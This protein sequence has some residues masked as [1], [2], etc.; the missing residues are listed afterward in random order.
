MLYISQVF[1]VFELHNVAQDEQD[2]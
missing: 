2:A 1:N